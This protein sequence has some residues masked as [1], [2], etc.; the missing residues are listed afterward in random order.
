M[1]LQ[2]RQ[3]HQALAQGFIESRVRQHARLRLQHSGIA[4]TLAFIDF[5]QRHVIQHAVL[6]VA[7]LHF[8][9]DIGHR[10]AAPGIHLGERVG[11]RRLGT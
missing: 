8:E 10:L 3:I 7:A 11:L 1:T 4:L 6:P 2:L 5:R 9:R